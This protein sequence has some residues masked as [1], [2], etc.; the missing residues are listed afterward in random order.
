MVNLKC[1]NNRKPDNQTREFNQRII[2][3]DL[4]KNARSNCIIGSSNFREER[5]HFQ[6]SPIDYHERL[7]LHFRFI[8]FIY[9]IYIDTPQAAECSSTVQLIFNTIYHTSKAFDTTNYDIRTFKLFKYGELPDIET[10]R[11]ETIR[12]RHNRHSNEFSSRIH[13]AQKSHPRTTRAKIRIT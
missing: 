4:R 13:P 7:W 5:H 6:V 11:A 10:V 12:S 1:K 9:V 8:S 3:A 2:I